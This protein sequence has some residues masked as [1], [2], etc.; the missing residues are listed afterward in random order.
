MNTRTVTIMG[1]VTLILVGAAL[2]VSQHKDPVPPQTGQRVFPDLMAKINEVAAIRVSA[3]GRTF[4]IVREGESWNVKEKHQYPAH[5]GKIREVLIGLGELTILEP[6]TRKPEFYE[7]LGVQDVEAEGA[8]ST[9]V[10][11]TDSAGTTLT[12]LIV[13]NQLPVQGNSG[14]DELYVRKSG[15]PQTWLAVGNLSVATMADEWLD[16][17]FLEVE[18]KRVRSLRISHPDATTLRLAKEKPDEDDFTVVN[19]PTGTEVES[20][21]VV[22]NIVSTISSLSFEDVKPKSEVTFDDQSVVTAVFETFD[23][24]EVTVTFLPKDEKHYVKVS[25]AFNN[26]LIWK[27]ESEEAANTEKQAEETPEPEKAEK[28]EKTEKEET[29]VST[30]EK[31]V[32]KP[33]AEVKAEI[34]ALN[35]R[36][37]E[38]VY[39]IP[40]FRAETILKKPEDLIKTSP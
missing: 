35:K 38:W 23:G 2:W 7:K 4:T 8:S 30:P 17:D 39:V 34:E 31:P 1:A 10:T 37:G 12:K 11:L 19:L 5:V 27:P 20:Q 32:I 33:E 3:T 21:F 29:D 25:A 18:P 22:N 24:L 13:G 36:V 15:D 6:K 14:Q 28:A 26:D 9:E 40:E 16:K